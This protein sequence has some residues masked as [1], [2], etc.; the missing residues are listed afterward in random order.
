MEIKHKNRI[1]MQIQLNKPAPIG[2]TVGIEAQ[3]TKGPDEKML[4]AVAAK[5][6][7]DESDD[8][9]VPASTVTAPTAKAKPAQPARKAGSY[10][11]GDT[12]TDEG[13][14][15]D[16]AD[17]DEGVPEKK[18]PKQEAS[19]QT[20]VN[21]DD[22]DTDDDDGVDFATIAD[23]LAE[24][25][26]IVEKPEGFDDEDFNETSFLTLLE[27]NI[28]RFKEEAYSEGEKAL[29]EYFQNTLD[30]RLIEA[31]NFQTANPNLSPEE[32]T[33]YLDGL[34]YQA[35]VEEFDPNQEQ[36]AIAII[37]DYNL[38][39]QTPTDEVED[40]I[41]QLK[42]AG[43]LTKE[44]KRLLPKLKRELAAK[45][46]AEDAAVTERVQQ[47]KAARQRVVRKAQELVKSN[48]LFGV[49][50]SKQDVSFLL[51]GLSYDQA[52]IIL[53]G[54]VTAKGDYATH[55][56]Q[57]N[58][59]SEAGIK[60]LMLAMM[61]LNGQEEKILSSFK[62]KAT[63]SEV[64]KMVEHKNGLPKFGQPKQKT[65]KPPQQNPLLAGLFKQ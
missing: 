16:L 63:S 54:G 50:L 30:P 4:K 5:Y 52:D 33:R 36:D 14:F 17:P 60:R 45:K 8:D 7:G 58:M 39:H 10:F 31:I 3:Q 43:T 11:L 32:V 40:E 55:L 24:K 51:G 18:T 25:D 35:S 57:K 42:E 22:S 53:P 48:D 59:T 23:L 1:L 44:A 26:L 12:D 21:D 34:V 19:A 28:N 41:G 9:T 64:K 6:F 27:H 56:L 62:A 47:E 13:E 38:L 15:E 46:E 20:T 2:G 29:Q 49:P 65:N 61:I 37:R